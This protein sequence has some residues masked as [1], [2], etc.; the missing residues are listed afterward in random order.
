MS[1]STN[2]LFDQDLL[3][4]MVTGGYVRVQQHP[5]LPLSILN[6]SE[7]AQYERVW[8]SVTMQCRGLIV[9]RDTNAVV[10]RSFPKFFNHNEPM[11]DGVDMAGPV[12]VTDKLDG[13]LGILYP[14]AG[15]HAIATR[16]SFTS[17]QAEHANHVWKTRYAF[18][19]EPLPAF[20]YLFEIVY[21][22]NR[23]VVDYGG[24]DDLILLGAVHVG[25]GQTYG[26]DTAHGWPGPVAE[27]FPYESLAG[28]LAAPPR[29][30]KEGLVVH[31]LDSDQ[32]VK[33]KQDDYVQL[34]RII[35]GFTAR[36]LW[37]RCAVHA[38]LAAH[39]DTT[40]KRLGQSLRMD[41]KEAQ[42]IVD[43]GPDWL[44]EIRKIAPEEF[45]DWIDATVNRLADEAKDIADI[46]EGEAF[47]LAE[48][49]RRDAA[50]AIADHPYRGL[51]FAALDG[52]PITAQAW[53]AVYPEH[54]KPFWTR[55]E[56]AA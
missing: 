51:I 32:R 22:E 6:Y 15:G 25:R 47:G 50:A 44:D 24:M 2:D 56:D 52:K 46:A 43:G 30:G 12:S 10:A 20:T 8:N 19:W 7:K 16:G 55:G 23:I 35:T 3:G 26:P 48:I 18:R 4:E 40:V 27:T 13:S 21:P 45:L 29:P 53:S 14:V 41:V 39:P 9:Q 34:H 28:S 31:F 49:T 33:I 38:V 42:G 54:E 37:E 17:E 36:R 11:A 1:V 5:A